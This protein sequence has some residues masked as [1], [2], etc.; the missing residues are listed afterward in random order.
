MVAKKGSARGWG[1]GRRNEMKGAHLRFERF[2][3][4][5]CWI[6]AMFIHFV[7]YCHMERKH[8]ISRIQYALALSLRWWRGVRA[9]ECHFDVWYGPVVVNATDSE[10]RG[11]TASSVRDKHNKIYEC[12]YNTQLPPELFLYQSNTWHTLNFRFFF[13]SFVRFFFFYFI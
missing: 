7:T 2:H 1:G 3:F 8:F 5:D 12:F 11:E 13:H 9:H 10:Q 6:S 4:F